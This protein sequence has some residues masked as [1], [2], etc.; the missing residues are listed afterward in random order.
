VAK[1]TRSPLIGRA[2]KEQRKEVRSE[3]IEIKEV[4]FAP[5]ASHLFALTA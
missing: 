3:K 5:S 1:S 2:F 4:T